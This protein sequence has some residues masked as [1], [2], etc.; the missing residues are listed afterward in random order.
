MP[1]S[2]RARLDK[3]THPGLALDKYARSWG[4][5]A[6]SKWQEKVQK[7]VC[8][9]VAKLSA[10]CPNGL[11]FAALQRRRFSGLRALTT[12]TFS[13]VTTG[14]LTLHLARASVLENAGICLHPLYGFTYLPGTGL[15]GMARAYAETVWKAVQADRRKAEDSIL[16]VFGNE[17][18]EP[19]AE[20]QH[21]GFIVFHDAWP[22]EWPKLVVDIVNCHHPKYYGGSD[23]PGDWENPVPVYFLAVPDGVKFSFAL[24]KVRSDVLDEFLGLAREWLVGALEHAGAGAKT[25]AGYGVF[26]IIAEAETDKR[27]SERVREVWT[28]AL[29]GGTRAEFETV[30]ELVSPA[31]L[32]G[33][34]Q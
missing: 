27:V 33:A 3:S 4:G 30:L 20:R 12:E 9:Q 25:A 2:I 19:R 13:A 18:G 34:S 17:S 26:K 8:E 32:A 29:S 7:A 11:D 15:K 6:D 16:A 28:G 5:S 14:P 22:H 24:S 23:G 10:S 21:V 1:K 31:F